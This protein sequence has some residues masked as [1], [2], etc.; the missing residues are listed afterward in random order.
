MKIEKGKTSNGYAK[1]ELRGSPDLTCGGYLTFCVST[2]K[3]I[4]VSKILS[5]CISSLQPPPFPTIGT[6][7]KWHNRPAFTPFSVLPLTSD[8]SDKTHYTTF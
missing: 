8:F 3:K 4:T 5:M 2:I 1:F 6:G 7:M